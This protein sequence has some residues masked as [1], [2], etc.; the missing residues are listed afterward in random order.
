MQN[1]HLIILLTTLVVIS[2]VFLLF[3]GEPVQAPTNSGTKIIDSTPEV[4]IVTESGNQVSTT[5]HESDPV[6]TDSI[7]GMTTAQAVAYTNTNTI[8]FRVGTIDGEA[9]ALDMD[10]RVGRITAETINDI[11]VSY[12]VEY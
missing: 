9:L 11:V 6:A 12:T 3:T 8:D 5:P 4:P 10:Y 1:K 7:I 2:A